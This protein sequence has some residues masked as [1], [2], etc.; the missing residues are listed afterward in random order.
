MYPGSKAAYSDAPGLLARYRGVRGGCGA[1]AWRALVA[2]AHPS[3]GQPL[4]GRA[5][6]SL[7]PELGV[8]PTGVFQA[9]WCV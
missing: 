8:G 7:C 9:L 6:T 4:L 1:P 3:I 5:A 2:G